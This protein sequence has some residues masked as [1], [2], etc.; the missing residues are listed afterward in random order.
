MTLK[1]LL[2]LQPSITWPGFS[3]VGFFSE[4][5]DQNRGCQAFRIF[6]GQTQ[7]VA[8]ENKYWCIWSPPPAVLSSIHFNL[9]LMGSYKQSIAPEL[10]KENIALGSKITLTIVGKDYLVM[11]VCVNSPLNAYV[12]SQDQG[13]CSFKWNMTLQPRSWSSN[14]LK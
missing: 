11:Y 9:L 3:P 13:T 8:L 12:Q 2:W 4:E 1:C 10:E 6:I 7:A 14:P 5:V